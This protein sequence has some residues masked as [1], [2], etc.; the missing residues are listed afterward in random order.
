MDYARA[1]SEY[2]ARGINERARTIN[3]A[4][5]SLPVGARLCIHDHP[6]VLPHASGEP[7]TWR[8]DLHVL[9]TPADT[10]DVRPC[11]RIGPMPTVAELAAQIGLVCR[12]ARCCCPPGVGHRHP[13]YA[14]Y[15]E[16]LERSRIVD[17]PA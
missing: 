2:V 4:L 14:A 3:D 5:R 17:H 16:L 15:L 1:L 12:C 8:W 11:E 10:C 13:A 9:L 6:T 7:V